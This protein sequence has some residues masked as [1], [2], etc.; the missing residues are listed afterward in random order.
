MSRTYEIV[1]HDCRSRL[2]IGQGWPDTRVYLYGGD[3]HFKALEAFLFGHQRHRIEFGDCEVLDLDDY[4]EIEV[5]ETEA[6]Q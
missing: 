3:D 5:D 2:W 1:C 4:A 6:T